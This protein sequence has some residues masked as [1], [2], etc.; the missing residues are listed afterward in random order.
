M[1]AEAGEARRTDEWGPVSRGFR[2]S[3]PDGERG[4]VEDVT[5]R[6]GAVELVVA[7]GLFVRR[8]VTVRAHEIEA[9][10]PAARR[11][12]VRGSNGGVPAGDAAADLEAAG[13]IV[14]MPVRHSSRIGSPPQ[15]AA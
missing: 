10:L 14:R 8:L 12:V 4:C 5:L 13:G 15:E 11:I 9:I 7:T 3:L 1:A 6:G 2:V